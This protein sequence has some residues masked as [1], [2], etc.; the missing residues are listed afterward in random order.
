MHNTKGTTGYQHDH[1]VIFPEEDVLRQGRLNCPYFYKH[2][3]CVYSFPVLDHLV[4]G[5]PTC[6]L[7]ATFILLMSSKSIITHAWNISKP[8]CN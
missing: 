3:F 4:L 1:S 8:L 5:L 2:P 6:H 7:H